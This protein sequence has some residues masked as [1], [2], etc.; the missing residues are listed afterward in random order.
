MSFYST[1]I[2]SISPL[3]LSFYPE[4]YYDKMPLGDA[5]DKMFLL[6]AL[7]DRLFVIMNSLLILFED[8]FF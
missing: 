4:S 8:V 1:I 3:S 6:E 2:F 7:D 5:I